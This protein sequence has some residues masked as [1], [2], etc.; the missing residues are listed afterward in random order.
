MTRSRVISVLLGLI[1]V[2]CG[3]VIVLDQQGAFGND[4]FP[5]TAPA[6]G[7]NDYNLPPSS[8]SGTGGTPGNTLPPSSNP[9]PPADNSG[10]GDLK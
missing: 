1:L 4:P 2:A 7:N 10:Y 9:T 8:P 3:A 5:G 6:T